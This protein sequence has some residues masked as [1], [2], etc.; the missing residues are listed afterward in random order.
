MSQF[1]SKKDAIKEFIIC[2]KDPVYFIDNYIKLFHPQQGILPFKTWDFQKELFQKFND[3]QFNIILKSRQLGASWVSAAYAVWLMMFKREKNIMVI[4]TSFKT[5]ANLVKKVKFMIKNLPPWFEQFTKIEFDN[6]TNFTLSN[7]S[8]IKAAS[9]TTDV[10]RSEALSLLIIDEA[11]HIKTIDEVWTAAGPT[12]AAGGRCIAISSP[13]G[14]GNW[15][16]NEYTKA[17]KGENEFHPT[18]LMWD[19]HPDRDEEWEKKERKKYN[20]R[21]FDQE[22]CC[23]FLASGETVIDPSDLKRVYDLLK[24]PLLKTGPDKNLHIWEEYSNNNSY[25]IVADVARGDG[26]DSSTLHVIKTETLE[27]VAEYKGKITTEIFSKLLFDV[28]NEYGECMIV[29]ENNSL[30]H[31]VNNKLIE[32]NYSN[33]YYAEKGSHEYVAPYEAR[34]ATNVIAGFTTSHVTRPLMISKLEEF[35]RRGF[36]IINSERTYKELETF[37]WH[38]GKAEAQKGNND[39]L[40]IPLAIGCWI[41]DIALK[42]SQR[43]L[44]YKKTFLKSMMIT[45]TRLN[46]SIPGQIDYNRNISLPRPQLDNINK[47][48]SWL[49]KG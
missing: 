24:K 1:L 20:P 19:V 25:F 6:K 21:E 11:A 13:N 14:V 37:I 17:E 10:G 40:V 31:E 43:S 32:F 36:I 22:Y 46:T 12:M 28:G 49:L 3:Y 8:E 26:T 33:I 7:G 44:Q 15:F 4:A 41:R 45:K 39:D 38:N 29:V 18:K 9:T 48:Y 35:I 5:A 42:V 27:Q 2:G 34:N 30:G 16:Y 47:K 23:S